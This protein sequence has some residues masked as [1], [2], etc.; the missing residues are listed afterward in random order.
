MMSLVPGKISTP[1]A[2]WCRTR[3]FVHALVCHANN[4]NSRLLDADEYLSYTEGLKKRKN[5]NS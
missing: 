3:L 5:P 2:D 4:R 1:G